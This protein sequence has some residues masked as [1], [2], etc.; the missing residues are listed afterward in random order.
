MLSHLAPSFPPVSK[1]LAIYIYFFFI[2]LP[3]LK[4]LWGLDHGRVSWGHS[5]NS[6]WAISLGKREARGSLALVSG[7]VCVTPGN[8]LHQESEVTFV[9]KSKVISRVTLVMFFSSL[10]MKGSIQRNGVLLLW[11]CYS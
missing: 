4:E 8:I 1:L 6:L 5:T 11:V 10:E 9:R 3:V 2:F 7:A